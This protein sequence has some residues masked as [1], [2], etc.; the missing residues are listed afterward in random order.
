MFFFL[1]ETSGR[2]LKIK[3]HWMK[4]ACWGTVVGSGG[5]GG[6]EGGVGLLTG[7]PIS[8]KRL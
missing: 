5:G 7:G 3:R 4:L 8:P 1:S 2:F 6:G